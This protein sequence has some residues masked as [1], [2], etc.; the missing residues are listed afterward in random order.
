MKLVEYDPANI[1]FMPNLPRYE[2]LFQD[3]S[4][5]IVYKNCARRYF[6]RIVLGRVPR[7]EPYQVIF[8]FGS[9][10]HKFREILE[11]ESYGKAMEYIMSVTLTKPAPGSKFEYLNEMRLL[12][13][14]QAAYEHWQNEKKQKRIE[15]VAVEQPFNVELAPGL[16]IS[17]RADQIVKWNGKLW[18]RDW[19]TTSKDQNA[20]SRGIDPNDQAVRY[21]VGESL[22]HGQQ[23]QGIIFEAVY[24]TKTI[25]PKIFSVLSSRVK[26]QLDQWTK[27]QIFLNDNLKRSREL[28]I[29]PMEEHNCSWCPYADVCRKTS[30]QAMEGTLKQNYLLKPWDHNSVEQKEISE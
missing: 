29:W 25:G 21:I 28:D 18:G 24:N 30:E 6:Y 17:G 13:T 7:A 1:K 12:K 2:P 4:A 5:T 27:E 19:K 22:L 23:I 16:F 11:L 8:D 20:F 9:A 15:V 10:Y 3:H 26:Y 14:C